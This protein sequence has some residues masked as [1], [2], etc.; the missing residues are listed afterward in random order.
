MNKKLKAARNVRG[1]TIAKISQYLE[2]GET[3]YK[4]WEADRHRPNAG[5]LYALCHLLKKTP[6]M[7]GLEEIP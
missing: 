2:I 1:W 4:G 6:E 3:T 5:H 7:L